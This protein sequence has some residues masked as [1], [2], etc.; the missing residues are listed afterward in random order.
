MTGV[1]AGLGAAL[2]PRAAHAALSGAYSRPRQVVVLPEEGKAQIGR[3]LCEL[4]ET[5][6]FIHAQCDGRRGTDEIARAVADAY[7]VDVATAH[8]DVLACV[9]QLRE[10]GLVQ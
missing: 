7:D 2:M 6:R 8:V 9:A 1:A 4:N 10:M 3:V 5:A